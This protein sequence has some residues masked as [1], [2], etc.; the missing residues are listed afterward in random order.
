MLFER[1]PFN[2]IWTAYL[3]STGSPVDFSK[4]SNGL[5]RNLAGLGWVLRIFPLFPLPFLGK[6]LAP[7]AYLLPR[8]MLSVFHPPNMSPDVSAAVVA[9][10][11]SAAWRSV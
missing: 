8:F 11:S 9:L 10:A 5:L 2:F 4:F 7:W 3:L 1:I 6:W